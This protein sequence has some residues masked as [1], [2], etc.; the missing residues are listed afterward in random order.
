M[1]RRKQYPASREQTD[2]AFELYRERKQ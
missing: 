2:K 1:T